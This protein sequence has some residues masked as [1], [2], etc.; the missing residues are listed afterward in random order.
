MSK[1]TLIFKYRA[2][3]K[4]SIELLVNKELWLAKTDSLNDPFEC[5]M[6]FNEILESI[7]LNYK[8][9]PELKNKIEEETKKN[10]E[11]LGVCSF[12]QT[13]QNQLMWSH[14]ADEHRGFCIGFNKK[15]L[16]NQQP[17]L[18]EIEVNYQSDYPHKEI[19][20]LLDYLIKHKQTDEV[21]AI[22][23]SITF[24]IMKTKYTHWSYERE[25]RLTRDSYGA[26]P[27][28]EKCVNSIVFGLR[29]SERDKQTLRLL[30]SSDEWKHLK[31]FQAHKSN[32]KFGLIFEQI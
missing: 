31:W 25:L 27:F 23:S 8:I 2:F 12:S 20:L 6:I 17:Y 29:M 22:I 18:H 28:T 16:L 32:K 4:S 9:N 15:I 13:R 7:W 1:A 3:N 14:Y 10:L 30:L 26:L 19:F 24:V 21:E 5:Q 11:N